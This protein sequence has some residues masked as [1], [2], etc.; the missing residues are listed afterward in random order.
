MANEAGFDISDAP[1]GYENT[2]SYWWALWN[3]V[4][5]TFRVGLL[6]L[7]AMTILGVL[8]G[9]A[10]LST[11]WLI[12]KIALAYVEIIRNTPILIQL[13][14]IYFSVILAFPDITEA[15]RPFNLPIF[16]SNR[17]GPDPLARVDDLCLSLDRI[18]YFGTYSIPG[19]LDVPGSSRR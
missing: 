9:I 1:L 16:L 4:A 3:G 11:N 17:G 2:D 13:L 5:N 15:W 8:A 10:R 12:A 19:C 7:V 6:S 18:P 14:L